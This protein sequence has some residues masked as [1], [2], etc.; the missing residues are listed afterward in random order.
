MSLTICLVGCGT[1]TPTPSPT[2]TPTPSLVEDVIT[3]A[4]TLASTKALTPTQ[5]PINT[6]YERRPLP[7]TWTATTTPTATLS[8][9]PTTTPSITPTPT[10]TPTRTLDELCE[11]FNPQIAYNPET[12]Y[13]KEAVLTVFAGIDDPQ[14]VTI[15]EATERITGESI[16]SALD[17]NGLYQMGEM[18][19]V[20]FPV[21][22]TYDWVFY[23][24]APDET[25]LCHV[26][27]VLII[28]ETTLFDLI[29]TVA[30]PTAT[31][32]RTPALYDVPNATPTS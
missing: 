11:A 18:P 9:T 28:R 14:F 3:P 4:I 16:Q 27:G 23:L 12:A 26:R 15:F 31:P 20:N 8:P 13:P 7:A 19:L 32:T 17:T 30:P 25:Q 22:G 1:S 21:V 10:T 2:I 24:Q 29:P 6:P 5:A